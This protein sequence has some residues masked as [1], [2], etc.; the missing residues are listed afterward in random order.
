MSEA[1]SLDIWWLGSN[2]MD[3]WIQFHNCWLW[4]LPMGLTQA[5]GGVSSRLYWW[6][7]RV[8]KG[9]CNDMGWVLWWDEV[10]VMRN[11]TK[12]QGWLLVQRYLHFGFYSY[13]ILASNLWT[14]WMDS[15]RPPVR[16]FKVNNDEFV[17][18]KT[19]LQTRV[20]KCRV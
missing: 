4:L 16:V 2:S 6:D 8:W 3:W 17:S 1:A 9:E 13:S 7:L 19:A 20:H 5:R 10:R 12:N 11:S 15:G 18:K 14:I